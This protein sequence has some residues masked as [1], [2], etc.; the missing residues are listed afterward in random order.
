MTNAVKFTEKGEILIQVEWDEPNDL[1]FAVRDT[2]I[3][4]PADR[5]DRLFQ[6]FSQVDASTSRR[7]GGTGLGLAISKRLTEM[8]GGRMWVKST[9][10]QGSTFHFNIQASTAPEPKRS[11]VEQPQLTGR[12][13]LIVDDNATNRQILMMQTRSWRMDPKA[14]ENPQQALEWIEAGEQYDV[15]ILDMQM[16][17]MDGV[18]LAKAIRASRDRTALPLVMLT[19]LG[20][21][22]VEGRAEFAA[23]LTKPVKSSQLYNALAGIFAGEVIEVAQEKPMFD[24]SLAQRVPLRILLADDNATN[25]KVALALFKKMGYTADIASNGL[26]VVE[27]V[28]RQKYDVVF[29]DVQ[30]PE[31]DGFE[32][33]AV[34][35]D[36]MPANRQPRIVAM[37]ANAMEGD[38]ELCLAAR[39]DD[40]VAKPIRVGELQAA[41]ERSYSN[42]AP[43]SP[44]D[45]GPQVDNDIWAALRE[46]DKDDPGLI[47]E[48]VNSFRS[49]AP[50]ILL[51]VKE[52]VT[53]K[54][55][56][57]LAKSAHNLRGSSG[58]LGMLRLAAV[59]AELEKKG[60]AGALEGADE[61]MAE[62]EREYA[63]ALELLAKM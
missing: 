15:A 53:A 2:G 12:K 24:A 39:M 56:V 37:T 25:Q 36:Q 13:V 52:A 58:N 49:E 26:E 22:E 54:D 55:A 41:L 51:K 43:A 34:I 27:A 9:P 18:Q 61:L 63:N 30:M 1:H 23:F 48:L 14:T 21:R 59:S 42:A 35:R 47:T 6:S 40:Y 45:D 5:M 44:V 8:M 29:M 32:A 60:K 4:I 46:A 28:K 50:G 57:K 3:G 38:R 20:I 31:M 33:T 16:P 19:S 62:A 10:G 17:D 7:Y 11:M